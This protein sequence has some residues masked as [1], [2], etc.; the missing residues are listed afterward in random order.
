MRLQNYL[1]EISKVSTKEAEKILDKGFSDYKKILKTQK[2]YF[3]LPRFFKL[4]A[5][6]KESKI[7]F[8][9][10]SGILAKAKGVSNTEGG[11]SLINKGE[12]PEIWIKLS[13]KELK[14]LS[15]DSGIENVK[16]RIKS[17]F[18]HELVHR[19]QTQAKS[20]EY[21]DILMSK[22]KKIKQ[23][24][25]SQNYDDYLSSK[26]EIEA[27]ARQA[28]EE[29]EKDEKEI[30]Y[31]YLNSDTSEKVKR[32]FLKKLYQYVDMYG[33]STAKENLKNMFKNY[34]RLDKMADSI[35]KMMDL[36]NDLLGIG[37]DE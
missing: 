5:A 10:E 3:W 1:T 19:K 4:A 24:L 30:I 20:K 32:R 11:F 15:T 28:T 14:S 22:S 29:L 25:K 9:S 37:D 34:K 17:V 21:L 26:S 13:K 7:F 23:K 18:I 6:F 31:T 35:E 8:F 12:I 33:S 16:K 2:I 27:F 36:F